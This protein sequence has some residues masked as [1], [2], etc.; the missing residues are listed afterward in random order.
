MFGQSY[1]NAPNSQAVKDYTEL[2]NWFAG[3]D[4]PESVQSFTFEPDVLRETTPRQRGVYRGCIALILRSEA[5]DFHS[6]NRITASMVLEKKIDDH[7]VF[8]KGYLVDADVKVTATLRD[9]ILNRTLIDKETNIRI[10]K[11]APVVYLAEIEAELG[12]DR[13]DKVLE[14]HLLPGGQGSTLREGRFDEFLD[15][16]QERLAKAIED[17]TS[18]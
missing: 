5:R 15:E 17:V 12:A 1:E 7:H 16:R 2:T 6:G 8:P 13:L 14:S 11:K 18:D 3:G 9:C 10:G 4:E